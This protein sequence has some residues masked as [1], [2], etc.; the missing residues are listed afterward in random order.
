MKTRSALRFLGLA[1]LLTCVVSMPVSAGDDSSGVIHCSVDLSRPFRVY[2]M[3]QRDKAWSQSLV[4]NLKYSGRVFHF[5]RTS[6]PLAIDN[7]K[8]DGQVYQ[9]LENPN[10]FYVLRSDAILQLGTEHPYNPAVLG[11]S[12]HAPSSRQFIVALNFFAT[13]VPFE[14]STPVG[15]GPVAW[16][17]RVVNRLP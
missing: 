1:V 6:L 9:A 5:V 16:M 7:V 14:S 15:R 11:F 4:R 12:M 3:T 13:G 8:E 2:V 17:G 10:I